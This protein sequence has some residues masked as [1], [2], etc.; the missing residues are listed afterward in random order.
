MRPTDNDRVIPPDPRV[1]TAAIVMV[2]TGTVAGLFLI[3]F[4]R[5]YLSGMEELIREDPDEATRR[6]G[7]AL[8][9]LAWGLAV[10]PVT[11]AIALLSLA[12]RS[13]QH[14]QYPPPG[15]R[16]I[17]PV[18]VRSGPAARRIAGVAALLAALLLAGTVVMIITLTRIEAWLVSQGP[19]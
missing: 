9:V 19:T 6:I 12:I 8:H 3:A 15:A 11:A 17:R 7:A 16:P 14:Q 10:A 4:L 2:A 1:R 18:R 13:W 5:N